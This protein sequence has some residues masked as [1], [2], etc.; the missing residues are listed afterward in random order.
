MC[1]TIALS[2]A[3]ANHK[4]KPHQMR[5]RQTIRWSWQTWPK[6][7]QLRILT[8]CSA[9]RRLIPATEIAQAALRIC[10]RLSQGAIIT[11]KRRQASSAMQ[12][13]QVVKTIALV[14]L[15]RVL[16]S[17][18]SLQQCE[19]L[20]STKES[21]AHLRS[22]RLQQQLNSSHNKYHHCLSRELHPSVKS[23]QLLQQS[24]DPSQMA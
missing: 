1:L 21:Q 17:C 11:V 6:P 24:V 12:R 16:Q 8:P 19:S 15:C 22:L 18:Y 4:L 2:L 7:V 23:P 20:T 13:P 10:N 5:R 14:S 3:S 9:S